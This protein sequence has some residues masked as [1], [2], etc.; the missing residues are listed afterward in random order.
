M[1]KLQEKKLLSVS[2]PSRKEEARQ[3][4]YKTKRAAARMIHHWRLD[5]QTGAYIEAV[6]QAPQHETVMRPTE[7][8][9]QPPPPA[10]VEPPVLLLPPSDLHLPHS[11]PWNT[12]SSLGPLELPAISSSQSSS[13][14]SPATKISS[15]YLLLNAA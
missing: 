13:S 11:A 6:Q 7:P 2:R 15:V 9:A 10:P 12:L 14:S 1:A 5:R 8:A 4:K 3:E